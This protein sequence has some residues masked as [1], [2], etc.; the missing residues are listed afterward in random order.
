MLKFNDKIVAS[1]KATNPQYFD[2]LKAAVAGKSLFQIKQEMVKG[3]SLIIAALENG[4]DTGPLI[5]SAKVIAEATKDNYNL[6]NKA[7]VQKFSDNI[8]N[9]LLT[10]NAV[11]KNSPGI[12][13]ASRPTLLQED[14][15]LT[16]AAVVALVVWE[17][18]AAV[19][20]V[21]VATVGV[22]AAA[23]FIY[24]GSVIVSD[25][26]AQSA[27]GLGSLTNDQVVLSVSNNY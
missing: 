5:K 10:S 9:K 1:I 24:K 2:E 25:T 21:A 26:E 8:K 18:G 12:T 4:Q 11:V 27:L 15:C 22:V 19:N 17:A 3:G 20:V 16:V 23:V 7:D 6:N 14:A 13:R